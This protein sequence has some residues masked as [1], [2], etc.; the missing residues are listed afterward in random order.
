[1]NK[2]TRLITTTLMA[3][4]VALPCNSTKEIKCDLFGNTLKKFETKGTYF[5]GELTEM[6]RTELTDNEKTTLK[7][8]L[9]LIHI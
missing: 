4:G 5:Y 3:L 7:E 6:P 2:L 1:M 8:Y 9:S